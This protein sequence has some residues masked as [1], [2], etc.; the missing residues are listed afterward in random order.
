[1]KSELIYTENGDLIVQKPNGLRYEFNNV[2]APDLGFDYSVLVYSD[3][4][5]KIDQW[6][7][8]LGFDQQEMVPLND[9]EKDAIELYIENS[10]PPIGYNLNRQFINHLNDLCQGFVNDQSNAYGFNGLTE[11][12]YAGR[13]SSAHPLRSEARRVLEYCDAVWCCYSQVEEE[14]NNTREDYLK[15]FEEYQSVI[16]TPLVSPDSQ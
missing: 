10:E 8:D 13:E 14:I 2:D 6:N 15:S 5:V 16:P 12:L 9:Q 1:M 3:L 4:E 7:D 11:V